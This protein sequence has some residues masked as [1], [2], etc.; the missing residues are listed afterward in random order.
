MSNGTDDKKA[1][2]APRDPMAPP[3]LPSEAAID[4]ARSAQQS[5]PPLPFGTASRIPNVPHHVQST[6]PQGSAPASPAPRPKAQSY[7]DWHGIVGQGEDILWEGRGQADGA[8]HQRPFARNIRRGK[9]IGPIIMIVFALFWMG[10]ASRGGGF[11]WMFG[12]IFLYKGGRELIAAWKASPINAAQEAVGNSAI[13]RYLLT[14]RAAYIMRGTQASERFAITPD[15][16]ITLENGRLSSVYFTSGAGSE[17][18]R[19]GNNQQR[20][21][22][23]NIDDA[24]EVYQLM[25][26]IAREMR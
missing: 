13:P 2:S 26:D 19:F 10:V 7:P 24:A 22:F 4:N 23:E 1:A 9:L 8:F 17:Q 25:R 15:T 3:P 12:L 18:R 14:N 6:E 20:A 16:R 5:P 11:V 21:G